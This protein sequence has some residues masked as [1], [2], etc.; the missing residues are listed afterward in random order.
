M[1]GFEEQEIS[2]YWRLCDELSVKNAALLAVGVDPASKE[3]SLC[4]SWNVHERPFGYEAAKHAI[5]NA[6][7]KGLIKGEHRGHLDHDMN[8]RE[9]GEIPG[10]TDI[11]LSL[12]DRDS[13]AQWLMSRG[14]NNGFFFP[15]QQEV[16]GPEY[17][18]PGI[19]G[20]QKSWPLL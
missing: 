9:M 16:T 17:L 7:R 8:G 20:F 6:L 3:G 1:S 18:N 15:A 5:G 4:E 13:L 12:M 19:P 14:V 10:T 2:V 11:D